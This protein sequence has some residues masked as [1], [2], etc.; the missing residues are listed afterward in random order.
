[1]MEQIMR[2]S[3]GNPG[4]MTCLMGLLTGDIENSVAGLTILPKVEELGISGTDLYVLWSDLCG[5]D[6]QKMAE[7]CKNCLSDV[8]IDA[9]SRQDYSGR[10]LVKDY[11]DT[12]EG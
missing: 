12:V 3:N 2:L 5:K 6:Y 11:F 1:M 9:S 4:A 8:L 7:L 10:E